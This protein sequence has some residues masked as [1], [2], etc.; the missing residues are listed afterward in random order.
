MTTTWAGFS[1]KA[2]KD[3]LD[4]RSK[5]VNSLKKRPD[6]TRSGLFQVR[7]SDQYGT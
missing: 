6:T 3:E 4:E 7:K 2:I 5:A 1:K